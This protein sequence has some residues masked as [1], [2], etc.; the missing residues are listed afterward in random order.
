MENN[1]ENQEVELT[2]EQLKEEKAKILDKV[3]NPEKYSEENNE[4]VELPSE[5]KEEEAEEE[6]VY[7]NS[8]KN[9]DELKKGIDNL[10]SNLPDYVLEGMNDDALEKHYI[11]LRKEF[12][13]RKQESKEETEKPSENISDDLWQ[14][15]EQTY[16][17]TGSITEEQKNELRK[18]GIPD[19]MI[20][21]YIDG[22]KA[23]E[24]ANTLEQQQ[25]TEKIYDLAGGQEEYETIKSWAEETYS[26]EE[27]TAIASGTYDEIL[28]KMK[29][30][31]ADYIAKNGN[32]TQDRLR[33]RT[34]AKSG[35]GYKN[36]QEYLVDRMD[37]RYKTDGRYKAKVDSK[38][39]NSSFAS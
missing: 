9:V 5:N 32:I 34:S 10:G 4:E 6:R 3:K 26:Q 31:K 8:F 25:F 7:A 39:A 13:S 11:E 33:G 37:R 23:Q 18:S 36:Q 24:K 14:N 27:L 16:S 17:E 15:L 19:K 38:F 35:D 30:I 21:G 28:F 2:E 1:I 22:L 20:D 29:G 12:S